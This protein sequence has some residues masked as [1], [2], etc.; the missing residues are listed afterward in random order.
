[1]KVKFV[2]YSICSIVLFYSKCHFHKRFL[3]NTINYCIY[4]GNIKYCVAKEDHFL[5]F[6][7]VAIVEETAL[8]VQKSMSEIC[9]VGN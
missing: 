8:D 9:N 1:M 4:E 7:N 2:I 3:L 6:T 5:I